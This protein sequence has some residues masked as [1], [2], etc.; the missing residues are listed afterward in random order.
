MASSRHVANAAYSRERGERI[1]QLQYF[2]LAHNYYLCCLVGVLAVA[3]FRELRHGEV[4]RIHLPRTRVNKPGTAV[5]S[6]RLL[7]RA[8]KVVE[9]STRY[10]NSEGA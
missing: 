6:L 7:A 2:L 5:P 4:R 3:N 9:S 1:T 10:I 8:N